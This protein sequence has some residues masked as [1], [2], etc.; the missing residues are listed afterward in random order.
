MRVRV[1]AVV[2]PCLRMSPHISDLKRGTAP[3]HRVLGLA[4]WF[5]SLLAAVLCV[6]VW[7]VQQSRRDARSAHAEA[8]AASIEGQTLRL[9]R[10]LQ[11]ALEGLAVDSVQLARD[12]PE[13]AP[14]LLRQSA[15]DIAARHS[16][17]SALS[18]LE[19]AT[20]Q[21]QEPA[22]LVIGS[23]QTNASGESVL[24][25][26]MAVAAG[27]FS[28]IR[29]EV[30]SEALGAL[31]DQPGLEFRGGALLRLEGAG[32]IAVR[33]KGRQGQAG[34]ALEAWAP[35]LTEDFVERSIGEYP[36]RVQVRLPQPDFELGLVPLLGLLLLALLAGLLARRALRRLGADL[37]SRQQTLD[38][39]THRHMRLY[40]A[41]QQAQLGSFDVDERGRLRH[42]SPLLRQLLGLPSEG[43]HCRTSLKSLPERVRRRVLELLRTPSAQPLEL[44]FQRVVEGRTHTLRLLAAWS[45]DASGLCLRGTLQDVSEAAAARRR[46]VEAEQRYRALFEKNPLPMWIVDASNLLFREFNQAAEQL[47]GYGAGEIRGDSLLRLLRPQDHAALRTELATHRGEGGQAA[48]FIHVDREGHEREVLQYTVAVELEGRRAWLML[49]LDLS[50]R[51]RAEAERAISD[52][53]F[54]LL[55]RATSDA[56]WDLDLQS[57]TLWWSDSFFSVFGYRRE[58][59]GP[60]LEFWS[61]R[62]HP[63]DA[64]RVNASLETAMAGA[65]DRW[66]ETYRFRHSEGHYVDVLDRGYVIRDDHGTAVRMVGGMIDVS[67]RSEFEQQLAWQASHDA[68]TGLPNRAEA[69]HKMVRRLEAQPAQGLNAV[70]VDLDH[71]KLINDSLG[72]GVGDEV[73]RQVG[74]RLQ[75]LACEQDFVARFGGDEF[76]LLCEGS[77]DA[78]QAE[79][80]LAQLGEPIEALGTLHYLT[81]SIGHA[82]W[83]NDADDAEGLL[84]AAELAMFAAKRQGRNCAVAYSP[85]FEQAVSTRL[86][87]VSRLRRALELGEFELHYQPK[88]SVDGRRFRGLE[89]LVRWRHPER[90]LLPPGQFIE[91][92]E[93]SGLIV[94]LGRWVLREACRQHTALRGAGC[95]DQAIAV[96]VSAAQFL[97]GDLVAEV[98]AALREHAMPAGALELE[99]TESVVM[100]DP[101]HA[102]AAM[103]RLK[104]LGVRLSMDDFGTG[105]SSLSNLKRLPLDSL[106]IDQAF[107]RDLGSDP[108]DEAICAAIIAMAKA[109][110]LKVIAEGVETEAQ[111]AWLAARGCEEVQGYLFARPTPIDACLALIEDCP[112]A[113]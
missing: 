109:L 78:P 70:L 31:L 58:E 53:R 15:A 99:L 80:L 24:P 97:R 20:S 44:E 94:P 12:V 6:W 95:G 25:L 32:V 85:E 86:D 112:D 67:E 68:L 9:L 59:V 38:A 76:L 14:E 108:E 2:E 54:R 41:Q 52:Q 81:P 101:A 30:R 110:G 79:R 105:Y 3:A 39:A 35:A 57:H 28:C 75:A 4:L 93:D 19:N 84:K 73:L 1:D 87:V 96:N 111:R 27:P 106:K 49:A 66:Q 88:F 22:Q 61:E 48:R 50:E 8:L 92:C 46:L 29:A 113:P 83:P 82:H 71:F 16:E 23:P 11:R 62:L 17:L 33:H 34:V 37:E 7:Q 63:E 26:L 104:A 5:L 90:G 102:A 13:R 18:L 43:L 64:D 65:V 51:M 72:H 69:L 42:L 107:V 103:A 56:I 100:E 98:E 77:F 36:L 10:G 47:Y 89:A 60:E 45:G 91:I 21:C 74:Q 55:A 40:D